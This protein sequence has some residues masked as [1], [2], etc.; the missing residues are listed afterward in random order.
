M[1]RGEHEFKMPADKVKLKEME[2]IL[3]QKDGKIQQQQS[4]MEALR[5]QSEQL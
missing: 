4:E 3:I 2:E 5:L 1:I